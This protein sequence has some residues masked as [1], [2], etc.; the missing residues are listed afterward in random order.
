NERLARFEMLLDFLSVPPDLAQFLTRQELDL[1]EVV[2]RAGLRR[3]AV[4]EDRLGTEGCGKLQGGGVGL[5]SA[6]LEF[7]VLSGYV[8]ESPHRTEIGSAAVARQIG[9]AEPDAVDVPPGDVQAAEDLFH[10]P[11]RLREDLGGLVGDAEP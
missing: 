9:G 7:A 1:V 4:G 2:L 3:I 6:R 8:V 10:L 11:G 5:A